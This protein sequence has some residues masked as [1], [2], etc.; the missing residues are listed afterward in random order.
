MTRY[1]EALPQLSGPRY[2]TDS[3]LETDL[4]FNQGVDLP[5]FAAFP[6]LRDPQGR[7]RLDRYFREH[8]SVAAGA[9]AGFVLES[10]T[11]RAN[12]DW[13][14]ILGYDRDELDAANRDAVVMLLTLR[15]ELE[16]QDGAQPMVVSGCVGPRGDAYSL[17]T[18]MNAL[19]ARDYHRDQV[20]SLAA[21]GVDQVTALTL[22]YVDEAAGFAL[23]AAD[24]GVPSVA[25][26]TVE[27]DGRLPDG[28]TLAEAVD[29]VDRAT[30]G[31]PS[32]YMVN[33]AHP[34]HFAG[35]LDPQAEWTPRVRGLRAN[36]SRKSHAELDEAEVLDDG[37]PVELGAEY[38]DLVR[39]QPWLTVLGGCCGTD[40]RHIREIARACFAG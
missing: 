24:A 3:G 33:C 21:A 15:D 32:Y 35:V 8:A 12:P 16:L 13:G 5:Q 7:A 38:A 6:L 19:E 18:L 31:A 34:T 9:G 11:W 40:V 2:L 25:S 27:T 1:G 14:S 23:A 28:T 30:G 4:V 37:D 22:G 39:D 36:A 20:V 10:V 26:F 29:E 17:G